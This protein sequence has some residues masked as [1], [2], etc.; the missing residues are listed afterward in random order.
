MDQNINKAIGVLGL[1]GGLELI[2][3]AVGMNQI[4]TALGPTYAPLVAGVCGISAIVLA[5]RILGISKMLG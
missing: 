3:G 2:G 4:P 5:D 1:I